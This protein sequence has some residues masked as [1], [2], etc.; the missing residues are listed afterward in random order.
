M[1]ARVLLPHQLGP[2]RVHRVA[3]RDDSAPQ[4]VVRVFA[5]FALALVETG[6]LLLRLLAGLR[7]SDADAAGIHSQKQRDDNDHKP[8]QPAADRESAA[9]ASAARRGARV[10]LHA[11]VEGHRTA[12]SLRR[13]GRC[14][15]SHTTIRACPWMPGLR[16]LLIRL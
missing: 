10:D 1:R 8:A 6:Y 3:R 2:H 14:P 15:A 4:D 16:P 11:L 5:G 9:G 13:P 12:P 7:S